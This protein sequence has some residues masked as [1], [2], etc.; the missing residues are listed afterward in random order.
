MNV[1]DLFCGA[2]GL[3]TGF[4][5]AGFQVTGVDRSRAA[6]RTFELNRTG[7]FILA[8]LSKEIIA[9]DCELVI[10]GPPCKPWSA[11]NTVLRGS[12]HPDYRL[13]SVFFEHIERIRPEAFLMENVPAVANTTIFARKLRRMRELG[14]SVDYQSIRYSEF[15]APTIR[16][17]LVVFG[18]RGAHAAQFF[19]SLSRH[20]RKPRTVKDAIWYLRDRGRGD[21][22]DHQWPEF[23]TIDKYSEFYRKCKYGWY[24]LQW[25]RP[26][27]SFGNVCKTYILHPDSFNGG[28]RR[29]IS[30]REA[31]RIMGFSKGFRLPREE[32]LEAKY[33]MAVDSVSP[34]FSVI[35]AKI[36]EA[37]LRGD[38]LDENQFRPEGPE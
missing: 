16:R 2:G 10:G 24:V 18:M 6:Q 34:C 26:A 36:T 5:K 15:G 30:V 21:E 23:R 8:D 20:H 14:Y 27:P 25:D 9:E 29:V 32:G 28:L 13:L 7:N 33:Q 4:R 22:P 38:V 37:I 12:K 11:V 1:L 17:R 31:W 35:A 19:K 3:A